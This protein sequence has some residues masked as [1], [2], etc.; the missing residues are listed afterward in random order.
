[1]TDHDDDI[2]DK[3][4]DEAENEHGD[5]H[6]PG[7]NEEHTEHEP[8]FAPTPSAPAFD[9]TDDADADPHSS[10]DHVG[11]SEDPHQDIY[12]D[13]GNPLEEEEDEEEDE[14]D[15]DSDSY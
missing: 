7:E 8:D 4:Q 15:G 10:F 12:G 6:E 14:Y 13:A 2:K 5:E 9:D 3:D 1:M 11:E